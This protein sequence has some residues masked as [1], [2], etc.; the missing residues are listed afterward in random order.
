M[1]D[2]NGMCECFDHDHA[3]R[4]QAKITQAKEQ[5]KMND[6]EHKF[7]MPFLLLKIKD[8]TLEFVTEPAFT[9]TITTWKLGCIELLDERERQDAAARF[10]TGWLRTHTITKKHMNSNHSL[11][12][13]PDGDKLDKELDRQLKAEKIFKRIGRQLRRMHKRRFISDSI[14]IWS[15]S[16]T[17]AERRIVRNLSDFS[18]DEK[19]SDSLPSMG[20]E[21]PTNKTRHSIEISMDEDEDEVGPAS[22]LSVADLLYLWLWLTLTSL[23]MKGLH[24]GRVWAL[25]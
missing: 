10:I 19:S 14:N 21:S 11:S 8:S 15:Q 2:C 6:R 23:R 16:T 12:S 1:N 24:V 18:D 3:M 25:Q 13:R 17:G 7:P 22:G 4:T 5:C 20:S 9:E